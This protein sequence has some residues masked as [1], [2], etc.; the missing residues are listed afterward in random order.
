MLRPLTWHCVPALKTK[1]DL[2]P[3]EVAKGI[4]KIHNRA[5]NSMAKDVLTVIVCSGLPP[6][7]NILNMRPAI[8]REA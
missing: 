8:P 3:L 6:T 7:A 1:P 4:E 2:K 5:L